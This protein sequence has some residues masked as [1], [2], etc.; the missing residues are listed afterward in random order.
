MTCHFP[1]A[2]SASSF[3]VSILHPPLLASDAEW[4]AA[5]PS[6]PQHFWFLVSW[7]LL[8]VPVWGQ[9]GA[10]HIFTGIFAIC[11]TCALSPSVGKT[12]DY[13]PLMGLVPCCICPIS[14]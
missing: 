14:S 3:A 4:P 7:G 13:L 10:A 9:D 2:E 6:K 5:S 11:A 1:A 12:S 8:G